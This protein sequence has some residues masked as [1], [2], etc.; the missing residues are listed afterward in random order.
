MDFLN[1]ILANLG[2]TAGLLVPILVIIVG[3]FLAWIVARIGA[4]LVRKALER[5]RLD[6]RVS[7]SLGTKT[8]ITRWVSGF[9]FWA[10]F[11]F[12]IWQLAVF[13]QNVA[14]IDTAAVQSPL[15]ALL[16]EWFGKLVNVGVFLLVAWLVASLLKFLV[17]RILNAT[18][19]DERLGEKV[20]KGKTENMNNSVGRAVFWLTFLVFMPSI[21]GAIGLG[22][23]ASSVQGLVNQVL[24]YIPGVIGAV[25]ILVLGSLFARI[26]RQVVT[27]FLEG[28]GVDSYGERVGLSKAQNAQSLSTLLGT[29]VY[30]FVMV[31]VIG[32]ALRVLNLDVLSAIS[33]QVLAKVNGTILSVLGAAVVLGLAYY[34]AKF[35]SEVATSISAGIGVNRLPAAL[36]FKTAKGAE[37]SN[38]VGYVVLVAVM[39]IAVQGTA[40]SVGLTAIAALVGTLMTF[41]GQVLFAIV[42]FLAGIY[43]S[44]IASSVIMTTGGSDASFLANIARWAILIFV[45]G[46][47]LTQVGVV[48][49]GTLL[50]IVLLAVGA[51]FALAFGLGGRDAAAGQL[52]K[53]FKPKK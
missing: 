52:E 35:V 10:L 36:G 15:G 50:Q 22:D 19:L 23:T 7:D 28:L 29:V 48:L 2:T 37:L 25:I 47:A 21:L 6:Q 3:L 12:A 20:A 45:A 53:W 46:M 30:V 1:E 38:V 4:F 43:L 16:A 17:V 42:I 14:G 40:Q 39:L 27:G 44:N 31:A 5:A 13:A 8:D 18:R 34:V 41:G 24:G 9:A 11:V 49:A 51:A 33:D 26:L 32:Q